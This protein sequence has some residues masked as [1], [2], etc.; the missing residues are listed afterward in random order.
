M[1]HHCLQCSENLCTPCCTVLVAVGGRLRVVIQLYHGLRWSLQQLLTVFSALRTSVPSALQYTLVS[2]PP[3]ITASSS[4]RSQ[5]T[6]RTVIEQEAQLSLRD[7][8]S[9]LSVEIWKMLHKCSTDCTSKGLQPA[10]GVRGHL[11]SVTLV[12]LPFDRP[13]MISY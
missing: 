7:R 1:A 2:K 5:P 3:D 12:P 8:A 10:N 4:K 9:T 6:A 13:H 11:M